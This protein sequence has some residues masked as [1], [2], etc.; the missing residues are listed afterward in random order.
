M[1]HCRFKRHATYTSD[2]HIKYKHIINSCTYIEYYTHER[3]HAII[4]I[5]ALPAWGCEVK[6]ITWPV[7]PA[8]HPSMLKFTFAR[9]FIRQIHVFTLETDGKARKIRLLCAQGQLA[10]PGI[11]SGVQLRSPVSPLL[12]FAQKKDETILW[13]RAEVL[14]A[15]TKHLHPME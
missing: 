2:G 10:P 1:E 7:T 5:C 8:N 14:Q 15:Q 4:F 12:R 11:L 6:L 9:R 3:G 13:K